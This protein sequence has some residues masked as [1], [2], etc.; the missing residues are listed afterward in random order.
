ML[1]LPLRLIVI[2]TVAAASCLPCLPGGVPAVAAPSA[3][4]FRSPLAG[5]LSVTR[6]FE[7]PPDPYAAGHRGVDLAG[8]PG[9]QVLSAG[10]GVVAFAGPVAGRSVVS[11]D[12]PGG[13]RTTY[14]PVDPAVRAG[15]VVAAGTPLGA[16]HAGHPDCP[17]AA[18]LH[19]GLRAGDTYLD[20]L[21]RLRRGRVRLLPL[22]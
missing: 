6:R 3:A 9:A 17:A 16:L 2:L 19:W 20:P 21:R 14:E 13:L 18:C 7:S 4:V 15:T 5:P 11:V 12:H 10:T 1:R 8:E 22:I